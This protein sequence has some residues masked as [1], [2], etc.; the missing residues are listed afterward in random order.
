MSGPADEAHRSLDD[1]MAA[2]YLRQYRAHG[3]GG[4]CPIH[5]VARCG[6]WVEAHV[7]LAQEGMLIGDQPNGQV[8]R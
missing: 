4:V 2:H 1:H 3:N 5:G 6:S 8:A 7:A